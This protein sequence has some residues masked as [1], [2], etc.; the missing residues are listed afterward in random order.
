VIDC[1]KYLL[2]YTMAVEAYWSLV[3]DLSEKY[4]GV[5][6]IPFDDGLPPLELFEATDVKNIGG[7]AVFMCWLKRQPN[8]LQWFVAIRKKYTGLVDVSV[9]ELKWLLPGVS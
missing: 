4:I 2:F 9:L 7:F 3:C 5:A 1:N 8:A 6:K